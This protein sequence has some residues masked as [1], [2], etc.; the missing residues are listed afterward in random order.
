MVVPTTTTLS[1]RRTTKSL[2]VIFD[3]EPKRLV[4]PLVD[5][6]HVEASSIPQAGNILSTHVALS[7]CKPDTFP[8]SY[9]ARLLGFDVPPLHLNNVHAGKSVELNVASLSLSTTN[10]QDGVNKIPPLGTWYAQ[11]R[12]SDERANALEFVDP[13]HQTLLHQNNK[14]LPTLLPTNSIPKMTR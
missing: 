14:M 9:H 5:V 1:T 6:P 7:H 13:F 10:K 2:L 8:L 4:N 11:T 3:D 12:N